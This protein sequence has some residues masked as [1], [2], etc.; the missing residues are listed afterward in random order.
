MDRVWPT[1]V[2]LLGEV[3]SRLSLGLPSGDK[4][5]PARATE[6]I[7]Q[8][9]VSTDGK[10]LPKYPRVRGGVRERRG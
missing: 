3:S 4:D 10:L 8:V 9:M 6:V 1:M 7:S 2:Y 5:H